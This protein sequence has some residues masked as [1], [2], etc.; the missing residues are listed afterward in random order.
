MFSLGPKAVGREDLRALS[1][2][3]WEATGDSESWL[4]GEKKAKYE[5][6]RKPIGE[7]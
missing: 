4:Q 6:L 1:L 3:P 2:H 7:C 5:V